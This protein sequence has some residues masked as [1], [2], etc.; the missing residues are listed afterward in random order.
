MKKM[1]LAGALTLAGITGATAIISETKVAAAAQ[2]QSF[3]K[4]YSLQTGGSSE[5]VPIFIQKGQELTN[6]PNRKTPSY[7]VYDSNHNL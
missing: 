2:E 7:N 3:T 6:H 5:Q 1:I 4:L